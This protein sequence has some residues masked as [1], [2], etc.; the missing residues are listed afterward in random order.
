MYARNPLYGFM[1]QP[2]AGEWGQAGK[3][4]ADNEG[5]VVSTIASPLMAGVGL[6]PVQDAK[7]LRFQ[8]STECVLNLVADHQNTTR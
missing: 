8:G 6:A 3:A 7:F 5:L 1:D 4:V 2:V